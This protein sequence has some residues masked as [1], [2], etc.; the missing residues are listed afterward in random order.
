MIASRAG[1]RLVLVRFAYL[2]VAHAFA[3]L[4]LLPMADREKDAG[5]LAL[6]HQ[7]TVVQRQSGPHQRI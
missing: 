5:T 7:L 3:V 1:S 2:A 6:R 4:R